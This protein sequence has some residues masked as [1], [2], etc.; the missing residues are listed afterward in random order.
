M[1]AFLEV[2]PA[3]SGE[4]GLIEN[5]AAGAGRTLKRASAT[6]ALKFVEVVV[7]FCA[8]FAGP[9]HFDPIPAL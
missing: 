9:N 2:A 4:V 1:R 7:W 6:Q 5:R 8:P 3:G